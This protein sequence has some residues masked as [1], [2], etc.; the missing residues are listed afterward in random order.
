MFEMRAKRTVLAWV[1]VVVPAVAGCALDAGLSDIEAEDG[2]GS[3]SI[4]ESYGGFY[5]DPYTGAAGQAECEPTD[6]LPGPCTEENDWEADGRANNRLTYTYDD[7]GN[8]V[9][10]Q[11]DIEADGVIDN[12]TAFTY[13]EDGNP[14][15]KERLDSLGSRSRHLYTYDTSGRLVREE[16]F[17]GDPGQLLYF[18]VYEFDENGNLLREEGLNARDN[19]STR[20]TIYTYDAD[21]QLVKKEEYQ[22][23]CIDWEV[24]TGD[25]VSRRTIYMYDGDGN[26]S[27]EEVDGSECEVTD[28]VVDERHQRTFDASGNLFVEISEYK[29]RSTVRKVHTY[30]EQGNRLKTESF[31]HQPGLPDD[32]PY[33]VS[34]WTYDSHGN[35][36]TSASD[37]TNDPADDNTRRVYTYDSDCNL[38]RVQSETVVENLVKTFR[39]R[40]NYTYDCWQ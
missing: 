11:W 32:T 7:S 38:I 24:F 36:L 8:V 35:M 4:V 15:V 21:E 18:D 40:T 26:P 5:G 27:L 20:R 23:F 9:L 29:D 6:K 25:V 39:S 17:Y 30:D 12:L 16:V 34:T 3:R 37:R 2:A 28:G 10:E 31:T 14:L 19:A 1:A 22:H 13:D 33:L